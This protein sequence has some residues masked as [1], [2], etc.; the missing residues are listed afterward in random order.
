[1]A[2][3]CRRTYS[4][5][6]TY[7][8]F[9]TRATIS[10]FR[11]KPTHCSTIEPGTRV[12]STYIVSSTIES[13]ILYNTQHTRDIIPNRPI[14][15]PF[16]IHIIIIEHKREKGKRNNGEAPCANSWNGGGQGTVGFYPTSCICRCIISRPSARA[17]GLVW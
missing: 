9:C 12:L 13:T 14:I 8:F 7:V 6:S 3:V 15:C 4:V 16:G 17:G 5:H 2:G 10:L 1:M 11:V